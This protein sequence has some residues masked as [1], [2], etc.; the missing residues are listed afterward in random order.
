LR[1]YKQGWSAKLIMVDTDIVIVGSV[2]ELFD[3]TPEFDYG[4]SIRASNPYPAGWCRL[5]R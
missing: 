1:R 5:N 4:L 3:D 2:Q